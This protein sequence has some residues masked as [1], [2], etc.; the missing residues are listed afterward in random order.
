MKTK[1]LTLIILATLLITNLSLTSAQ[2][3]SYLDTGYFYSTFFGGSSKDRV[4]DVYLDSKGNILIVGGTFSQDFPLRNA[5]QEVY[6]GG[7]QD[8]TEYMRLTG[9]GFVAKFT[10]DLEPI[11]STYLGG[12]GLDSALHVLAGGEDEVIVFGLT[13]STD[14]PVTFGSSPTGNDDGDTFIAMY[15][16]NGEF[17]GARLYCPDELDIINDVKK[18]S[19]GN[20]VMCGFTSSQSMYTTED[21][22]QSE[23]SGGIDGYIRVVTYDLENIIYSTY[24]GGS[25][26]D[27]I[28]EVAVGHDN[29]IYIDVG[30][31]STDFPVTENCI[32]SEFHGEETDNVI[33]KIDANRDLTVSTYFGGSGMDHIF[34]ISPGPGNSIAFVGR[35]WSSDYPATS[36]ALQPE[37]SEVEVDGILT[38]IS[39]S[40]ELIY[41]T[42]Y[43]FGGW[44][45]LLQVNMDEDSRL[46]ISGFVDSGG[47]ETVNAFQSEYF[48]STELV[49]MVMDED[50]EFNLISY[51]GGYNFE[52]PFSQK[53]QDGVLYLVGQTGSPQFPVSEGAFQSTLNGAEDG[54]IWIMNYDEYLSGDYTPDHRGTW[55]TPSMR[56]YLSYGFVIGAILVWYLFIRYYFSR[57]D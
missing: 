34:D 38:K 14:F 6:S 24:I 51:L 56:N 9:E 23:L 48:G 20:I 19:S 52:H 18:D 47:F 46:I 1:K 27:Y 22:F 50:N 15:T 40:G 12:S 33:V 3:G 37:Y 42:Y 13:T 4:R 39:E 30:T 54:F 49:I 17:I 31:N 7:E 16:S 8:P 41:S 21:A 57:S 29:S 43:G 25:G 26:H 32:R 35:T 55:F 53:I 11:W 36:E 2:N 44:D 28:G 5:A 45:S 10:P